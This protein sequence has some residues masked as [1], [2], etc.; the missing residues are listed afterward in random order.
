MI[1]LA[2]SGYTHALMVNLVEFILQIETNVL[3]RYLDRSKNSDT[4]T[5][6]TTNSNSILPPNPDAGEKRKLYFLYSWV[7]FLLSRNFFSFF[8]KSV[9]DFPS[10]GDGKHNTNLKKKKKSQMVQ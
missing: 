1:A 7:E 3:Q 6:I 2:W 10:L 4:A 9:A 8:D 5:N